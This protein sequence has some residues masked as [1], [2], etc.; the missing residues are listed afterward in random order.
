MP[1]AMTRKSRRND[2]AA[3]HS[4]LPDAKTLPLLAQSDHRFDV[5]IVRSVIEYRNGTLGQGQFSADPESALAW[6]PRVVQMRVE[7]A[8][9]GGRVGWRA[10]DSKDAALLVALI[11][12]QLSGAALRHP[13][14]L[15]SYLRKLPM[16]QHWEIENGDLF[17]V[18]LPELDCAARC[19]AYAA[20]LVIGD[21]WQLRDRIRVCPYR[22][23]GEDRSHLFLDYRADGEGKFARGEPMV[24]CCT[25]HGNNMRKRAFDAGVKS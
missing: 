4:A 10:S 6:V 3:W 21:R 18:T 2:T 9:G 8:L 25:R 23:V 14:L 5:Q 20:A 15:N 19:A 1:N 7:S 13:A 11:T 16:R 24:H 12:P 17:S 22:P